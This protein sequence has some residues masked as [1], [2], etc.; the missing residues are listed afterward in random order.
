MAVLEAPSSAGEKSRA[1][2]AATETRSQSGKGIHN[3]AGGRWLGV[4]SEMTSAD[5]L[6][7]PTGSA[8]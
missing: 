5:V 1:L 3:P 2:S 6:E 4:V 8:R 7:V